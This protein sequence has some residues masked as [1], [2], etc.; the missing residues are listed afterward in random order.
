MTTWMAFYRPNLPISVHLVYKSG[1]TGACVSIPVERGPEF[2]TVVP[3]PLNAKAT[4]NGLKV[5]IKDL[6]ASKFFKGDDDLLSTFAFAKIIL[7]DANVSF[8]PSVA[9]H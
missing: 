4:A 1:V 7:N 3:L 8:A 5:S 2:M 6:I 9:V